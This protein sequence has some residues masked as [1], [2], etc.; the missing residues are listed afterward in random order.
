MVSELQLRAV[1]P[2]PLKGLTGHSRWVQ[3]NHLEPRRQRTTLPLGPELFLL[4]P[5]C[6]SH[7]HT[8]S[9]TLVLTHTHS[10]PQL[11]QACWNIREKNISDYEAWGQENEGT[12]LKSQPREVWMDT[13][14]TPMRKIQRSGRRRGFQWEAP[15]KVQRQELC[16]SREGGERTAPQ[17]SW[18]G[19]L[20]VQGITAPWGSLK[21]N[22]TPHV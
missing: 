2:L 11:P 18:E 1:G 7:S 3:T 9:H 6:P 10:C 21:P 16:S 13:R 4:P 14:P 19:A 22:H 12:P 15:Q 17:P 5:P 8:R 20:W